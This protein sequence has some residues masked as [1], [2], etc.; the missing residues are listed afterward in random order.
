MRPLEK[1]YWSRLALGIVAAVVC[2]G[3]ALAANEIPQ[4]VDPF[5]TNTTLLFNSASIAI[6]IYL[7]S[8]YVIKMKYGNVIAKAS[9]IVTTGIGVYLLSWIVSWILFFTILVVVL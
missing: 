8:Y 6:I 4:V 2:A 9:K 3:Y 5:P 7:F 1:V